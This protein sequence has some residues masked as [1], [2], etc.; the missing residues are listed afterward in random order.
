MPDASLVDVPVRLQVTQ[1]TYAYIGTETFRFLVVPQGESIVVT[2][3]KDNRVTFFLYG[4]QVV[5]PKSRA[6]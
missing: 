3:G 6:T 1:V 5:C 2:I 4:A